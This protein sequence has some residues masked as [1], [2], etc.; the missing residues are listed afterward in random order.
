MVDRINKF[1]FLLYVVFDLERYHTL[2]KISTS[3]HDLIFT[4]IKV[5]RGTGS[6]LN[7][8]RL[9]SKSWDVEAI[10]CTKYLASTVARKVATIRFQCECLA[11]KFTLK[12]AFQQ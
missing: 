8:Q 9:L 3:W 2:M 6:L 10:I 1:F 5:W 4:H 7:P 12:C 11:C